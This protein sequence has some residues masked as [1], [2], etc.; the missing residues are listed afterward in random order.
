VQCNEN[1]KQSLY[2]HLYESK[3]TYSKAVCLIL[4][5]NYKTLPVSFYFSVFPPLS[6]ETINE[7]GNMRS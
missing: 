6:S 2:V 4:K 7:I 3:Y 1:G 5:W